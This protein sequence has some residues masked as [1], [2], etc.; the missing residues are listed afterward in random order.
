MSRNPSHF[1]LPSESESS[2][3]AGEDTSVLGKLLK[4]AMAEQSLSMRK[5]SEL[6]GI[7]TATISR[8]INN[9]QSAN[10]KHLQKFSKQLDI[11][12]EKLLSVTGISVNEGLSGHSRFIFNIIHDTLASLGIDLDTILSD[13][14]K[15]L[16][17]YEEY[18]KTKEGKNVIYNAFRVKT[19]EIGETGVIIDQ[20][21][22]LFNKFCS[23]DTSPDEQAVAGSAILYFILSMDVI[24]DY[25]FSIGYLDD[26]IAVNLVLKRLMLL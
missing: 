23:E 12:I 16:Q 9:K 25:M 22:L 15:E 24:P 13:I 7:C 19:A 8:I 14:Q 11:P 17:K 6:T 4:S 5:L 26:A 1:D 2:L 10:L 20:L 18:A 3:H 21:N